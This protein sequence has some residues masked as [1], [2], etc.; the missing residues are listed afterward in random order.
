MSKRALS[1]FTGLV[2]VF[3]MIA[4]P[5]R[6]DAQE[7]QPTPATD[8][9]R[10]EFL[11]P[12]LDAWGRVEKGQTVEELEK[13]L[14]KPIK[15][16][17]PKG[18]FEPNH[19]YSWTYGYVAKKSVVFPSDLAF[20]VRVEM[21]KVSSKSDPFGDVRLSRDGFPSVP[22]L[23]NPSDATEFFHY[24]RFVDL[25]WYASSGTYPMKYEIQID[26]FGLSGG[27]K[28]EATP[29][30]SSIPYLCYIFSGDTRGRWRVRAV[31]TKGTS[32]W[33]DYNSFSFKTDGVRKKK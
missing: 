25:R 33:S 18:G 31:N 19:V 1:I 26:Y 15:T 2:A 28:P 24:P 13:L 23:M 3:L 11:I 5:E 29:H 27:W 16:G 8:D 6:V 20:S 30:K 7:E 21:G 12:D 14:G 32:D 17:G 4:R 22:R 9:E 10:P